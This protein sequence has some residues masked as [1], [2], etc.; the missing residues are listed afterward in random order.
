MTAAK[1]LFV[2]GLRNAH[3]M[4]VQA[5]EMME[6]QSGRLDDYPEI[7]Q[8]VSSHLVETK[9]QL[10]RL[11]ECLKNCG[12]SA[13]TIK[14]TTQSVMGNMAAMAHSVADDEVLKNTFA[15]NAFENYEIAAY[16]SLLTMCGAAGAS[17]CKPL[18]EASLHEEE[19]MAAWIDQNVGKVTSMFLQRQQT[20]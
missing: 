3:A 5:R 16:K 15:N 6:R 11:D 1:D 18:L 2:L 9:Q 12:E 19:K 4:E 10:E 20:A 8:K 17:N 14:D 13:S 7:K